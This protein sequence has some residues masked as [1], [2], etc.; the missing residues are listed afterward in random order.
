MLE[1]GQQFLTMHKT[2]Y[3]YLMYVWGHSYELPEQDGWAQMEQF[4][5][6]MSHQDDIWY[7]TNIEIVNALENASRLQFTVNGDLCYNPNAASCWVSV[8]GK[9]YE[10]PGGTTTRLE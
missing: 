7:A 3:L 4:C 5:K 9:N 2:Q 6:T 1:L 8:G 10:L